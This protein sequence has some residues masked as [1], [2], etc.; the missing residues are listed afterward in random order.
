MTVAS[1]QTGIE[2]HDGFTG[3]MSSIIGA[4]Q[5]AMVEM[6]A[7]QGTM[8]ADIDMA[9]MEEAR[10]EIDRAAMAVAELEQAVSGLSALNIHIPQPDLP[11]AVQV[12]NGE[13]FPAQREPAGQGLLE[14]RPAVLPNAPP[15]SDAYGG[16]VQQEIDHISRRLDEV[17][18]LQQSINEV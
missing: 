9:G 8:S 4:V 6:E 1:I 2:L 11:G 14:A 5:S 15:V 3:V 13:T 10:G 12:V 18:R 7:M 16:A 17:A